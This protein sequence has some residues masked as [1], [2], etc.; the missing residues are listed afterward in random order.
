MQRRCDGRST[1]ALRPVTITRSFTKHAPGSVLVSFGDTKVVCTACFEQK[2]PAWMRGQDR[3]WVTAEYAML[4]GSAQSRVA[5]DSAQ[6]GRAQ[7]ISRMIGRCL[8]SVTD[9]KAMG[10]CMV[11]IDCDVLQADGGTRSAAI[12]GAWVALHDAFSLSVQSGYLEEIPLTGHCA[13][14]S[15]G[16]VNGTPLLDLCYAEDAEASVD[17]NVVMDGAG[18]IIEIQGAAEGRPFPRPLLDQMLVLGTKGAR[19]LVAIQEAAIAYE[20]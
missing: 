14:V 6:H 12:T 18:N 3:G 7:E 1:E 9:L 11:I 8:R 19:E 2:P 15:A 17:L 5:R 13:A 16:V 4:P 20:K 10:E